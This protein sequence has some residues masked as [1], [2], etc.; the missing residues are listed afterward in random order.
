MSPWSP[1]ELGRLSQCIVLCVVSFFS[2]TVI[3]DYKDNVL[4][5]MFLCRADT[6][7]S[8]NMTRLCSF[9]QR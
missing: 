8:D 6:V 5:N 3:F 2:K 9:V 1:G 7:T 4:S